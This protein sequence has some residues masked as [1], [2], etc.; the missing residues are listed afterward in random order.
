MAIYDFDELEWLTR[1]EYQ[2]LRNTPGL[3]AGGLAAA[4]IGYALYRRS[5]R[6]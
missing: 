6:H 5:K 1:E 2:K 3:I 4:G